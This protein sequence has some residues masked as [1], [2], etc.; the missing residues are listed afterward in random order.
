MSRR[1]I[2]DASE[3]KGMKRSTR[4][5]MIAGVAVF[6]A[7]VSGVSFAA[8]TTS[9]SKS[10]TVTAGSM[11]LSTATSAGAATITAFGPY[12]YTSTNE[13][14]TKPITVRNTGTVA[15]SLTS[16][17][18]SR[19]GNLGGG[20]VAVKFWV[21]SNAA[22]AVSTPVVS[23]NLNG[24]T[25]SLSTLNMT[26]AA[27]GSAILCASTTFTGNMTNQAGKTT[28]ATFGLNSSAG[29][30][31]NATDALAAASRTFTQD[32]FITT[33][34]NAPTGT[35]CVNDSSYTSI[36]VSWNTPAGFTAPNGGYNV[37]F[38]DG[39]VRNVSANS[40][41][42]SSNNGPTG[43]VTIRAVAANGT[44]SVN[45]QNVPIEPR[46]FGYFG[47]SCAN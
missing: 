4:M 15:A 45:S 44:E 35:T 11:G 17:E 40:A 32:I 18:I 2:E 27:S 42:L 36:T 37:Y 20:Q 3:R 5:S 13:T 38:N 24:G 9:A 8:W 30:N 39:L 41:Q 31:W 10:A 34:P 46:Y 23:T 19:S 26:I 21:G 1:Y 22:C 25:V 43:N 6:L 28:D 16:V 29:A 47:L 33:V 14:V 7:L 12:T